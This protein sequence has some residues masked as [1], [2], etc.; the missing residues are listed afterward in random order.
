MHTIS[1][2]SD[3]SFEFALSTLQWYVREAGIDAIALTNH[4][5]F[6][7]DQYHEIRDALNAT[8]FPVSKSTSQAGTS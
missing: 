5:V 8:V 6:D 7:R 2:V 4:N 3:H 1:T